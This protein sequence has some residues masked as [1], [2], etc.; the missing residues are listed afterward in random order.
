MKRT[1]LV[2][3]LA[4]KIRGQM[5]HSGPPGRFA[6][7]SAALPDRKEQ[8]KLD[9]AAGLV[10]FAVKLHK[11]LVSQLREMAERDGVD[12]NALTEQLIRAGLSAVGSAV[13]AKP[14]SKKV[15][16]KQVEVKQVEAKKAAPVKAAEEVK[17]P[18]KKAVAKKAAARKA[19]ATK[20]VKPKA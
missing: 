14:V 17:A 1:D 3:N 13:P 10:P 18:A 20:A 8:R 7:G 5:L 16:A 12:L 11:D 9:Q 2:K 6:Q 19:P 15:P 4:L